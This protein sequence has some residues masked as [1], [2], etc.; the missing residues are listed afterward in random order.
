MGK[1]SIKWT[2]KSVLA[3]AG[4]RDPVEVVQAAARAF[5]LKARESGWEGPPFN[6]LKLAEALRVQVVANANVADARVIFSETG[7]RIEYNPQQPRERVRFSIAHELAHL[8]FPDWKD[9]VRNRSHH[10]GGD[11]WQLEMLCNLVA[12]EF[13]LPI[14]SL[15]S[16]TEVAP[17]E[18]LMVQRRSFDVSTAQG[19][20]VASARKMTGRSD[21]K[22]GSA[23]FL[24]KDCSDLAPFI[25]SA[26]DVLADAFVRGDRVLL[27]GTR[28]DL[29]ARM[30]HSRSLAQCWR[31]AAH[32]G[33]SNGL[34][35]L[36]G[37]RALR[38]S[39]SLGTNGERTGPGLRRGTEGPTAQSPPLKGRG[40]L[41]R[42]GPARPLT[43]LTFTLTMLAHC[44]C[45]LRDVER[46]R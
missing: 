21:Y 29:F 16:S 10:Q 3:L 36:A 7:P 25:G 43:P 20:G 30:R 24:A 6:P 42:F 41:G 26:R 13:V 37:R 22:A 9:E 17:M 1:P 23:A 46:V 8:F 19:V 40:G 15:P 31:I 45:S 5:V 32:F 27:E 28:F 33:T 39:T 34:A 38:P 4:D 12:S 18:E 14:G 44:C 35:W 2:N 11:H